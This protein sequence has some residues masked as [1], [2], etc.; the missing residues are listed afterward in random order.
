MV[1]A[2]AWAAAAATSASLALLALGVA[3][4]TGEA[5]ALLLLAAEPSLFFLG[6]LILWIDELGLNSEDCVCIPNGNRFYLNSQF[7]KI[8]LPTLGIP[9]IGKFHYSKKG[10]MKSCFA[11]HPICNWV[12]KLV[13]W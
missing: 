7:I 8:P 6:D 11:F 3:A 5:E 2:A 4:F 1:A 12:L 10:K 9:Y 13:S